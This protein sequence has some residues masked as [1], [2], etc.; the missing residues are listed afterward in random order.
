MSELQTATLIG[1][2]CVL[3]AY[4]LGLYVGRLRHLAL[5]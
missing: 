1:T 2:G 3:I 5:V 4:W